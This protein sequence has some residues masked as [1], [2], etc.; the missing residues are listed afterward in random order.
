LIE[1][2][3]KSGAAA[4]L[5]QTTAAAGVESFD[6]IRT[7]SVFGRSNWIDVRDRPVSLCG[8]EMYPVKLY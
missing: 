6:P 1:F 5:S 7:V 8:T 4:G 2:D 3:G